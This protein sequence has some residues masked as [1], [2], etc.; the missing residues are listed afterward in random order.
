MKV[1]T[2]SRKRTEKRVGLRFLGI[3]V[4]PQTF[5]GLD[6]SGLPKIGGDFPRLTMF[7]GDN[8]SDEGPGYFDVQYLDEDT[9]IISQNEPGGIFVSVRDNTDW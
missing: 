7:G 2:F 4:E 3:S 1:K 5:L 9:L 6:V 8:E